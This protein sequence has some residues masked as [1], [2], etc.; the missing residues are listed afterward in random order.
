[1]KPA[2]FPLSLLFSLLMLFSL[3]PAQLQAKELTKAKNT[4]VPLY[5]L[6]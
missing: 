2:I 3:N 4:T 5:R 1:M 6:F